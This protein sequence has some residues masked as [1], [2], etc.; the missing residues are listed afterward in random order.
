MLKKIGDVNGNRS[1]TAGK[2]RLYVKGLVYLFI[3]VDNCKLYTNCIACGNTLQK[4][5]RKYGIDSD[6]IIITSCVF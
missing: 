4:Q 3:S 6:I 2:C 1:R 5:D